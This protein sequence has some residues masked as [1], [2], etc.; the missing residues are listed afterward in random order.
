MY[1]YYFLLSLVFFVV[2][3][4]VYG[5]GQTGTV[6]E[7]A[8]QKSEKNHTFE[9]QGKIDRVNAN[10][11]V[12]LGELVA[13]SS[14]LQPQLRYLDENSYVKATGPIINN[15][16]IVQG[17]YLINKG[18]T[19]TGRENSSGVSVSVMPFGQKIPPVAD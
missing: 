3:K 10:S 6:A 16:K 15:I 17:I 7:L 13:V 1:K 14:S 4:T 19:E 2:V 12:V 11:F 5:A 9:I 8:S 18:K